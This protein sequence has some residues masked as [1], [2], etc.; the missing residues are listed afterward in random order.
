MRTP[1]IAL[2]ISPLLLAFAPGCLPECPAGFTAVDVSADKPETPTGITVKPGDRVEVQAYGTW[3]CGMGPS[4]PN[5]A[6]VVPC[7]CPLRN[8]PLCA[9]VANA[10]EGQYRY[11]G[12]WTSFVVDR[13]GGERRLSL[14]PNENRGEHAGGERDVRHQKGTA[15]SDRFYTLSTRREEALVRVTRRSN[16]TKLPLKSNPGNSS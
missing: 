8:A 10:G 9:L 13:A 2:L 16:T 11:A 7:H 6:T 14:A 1:T 3:S 5:G 15:S 4:G 12:G